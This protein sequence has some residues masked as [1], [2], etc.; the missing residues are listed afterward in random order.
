MLCVMCVRKDGQFGDNDS[1]FLN[2]GTSARAFWFLLVA[3]ELMLEQTV[4]RYSI[5]NS[6]HPNRNLSTDSLHTS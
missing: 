1:M 3:G 5:L 6:L 4:D 2:P